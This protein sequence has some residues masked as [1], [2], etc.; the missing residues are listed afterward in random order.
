VDIRKLL[1]VNVLIFYEFQ[2]FVF[3]TEDENMHVPLLGDKNA[4]MNF[5]SSFL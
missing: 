2:F 3:D 5:G 1:N 4:I